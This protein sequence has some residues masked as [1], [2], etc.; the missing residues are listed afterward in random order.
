[1]RVPVSRPIVAMSESGFGISIISRPLFLELA[2][3]S[4]KA[5]KDGG[6]NMV[7]GVTG[8]GN[9]Y[10]EILYH[11]VKKY[12]ED[13][14][15]IL[16][17]KDKEIM[18]G[19][20]LND[21]VFSVTGFMQRTP[22]LSKRKKLLHS[23]PIA[24]N[25]IFRLEQPTTLIFADGTREQMADICSEQR[26][27]NLILVIDAV[28]SN[29]TA[30]RS[31]VMAL[32]GFRGAL[33][34]T[35]G[36]VKVVIVDI[37]GARYVG[38]LSDA[39]ATPII[40]EEDIIIG[41]ASDMKYGDALK[42]ARELMD[43][44]ETVLFVYSSYAV[45]NS[46]TVKVR[47]YA[48]EISS[49][50]RMVLRPFTLFRSGDLDTFE[51]KALDPSGNYNYNMFT[52]WGEAL[53]TCVIESSCLAATI[54]ICYDGK[55]YQEISISGNDIFSSDFHEEGF[56]VFVE[57]FSD[58]GNWV[59]SVLDGSRLLLLRNGISSVDGLV[60]YGEVTSNIHLMKNTN[61]L[62]LKPPL[63]ERRW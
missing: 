13:I 34:S 33:Q 17:G 30:Y 53:S 41:D 14:D 47:K 59:V 26:R 35:F 19:V 58:N 57:G 12:L 54:P 52:S 51:N 6:Y 60:S 50:G 16:P 1:M 5:L 61:V 3:R 28:Q 49:I 63:A 37:N 46:Q 36:E 56:S 27:S 9:D 15:D 40:S 39:S 21:G 45:S 62:L 11:S 24:G 42:I 43:G 29:Q 32:S 23:L 10:A 44:G 18:P 7:A 38:K 31:L 25:S 2:E 55:E 8:A 22:R 20:Y 48:L 4:L